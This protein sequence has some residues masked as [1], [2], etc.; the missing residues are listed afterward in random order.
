MYCVWCELNGV[1]VVLKM[2]M[3]CGCGCLMNGGFKVVELFERECA[4]FRA[5]DFERVFEYVDLFMLDSEF[6]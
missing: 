2:F 1:D 5:F 3:F 4:T 6:D